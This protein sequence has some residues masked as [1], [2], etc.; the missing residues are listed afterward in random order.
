MLALVFAMVRLA[1]EL[2]VL[3]CDRAGVTLVPWE[4]LFLWEFSLQSVPPHT[5][6]PSSGPI[7]YFSQV[8]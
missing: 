7:I 4:I 2:V 3:Q 5:I 1:W 6:S 8:H